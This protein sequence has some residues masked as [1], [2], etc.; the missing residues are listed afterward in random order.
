M[1]AMLVRGRLFFLRMRR[2]GWT[3]VGANSIAVI[4]NPWSV[5][6]QEHDPKHV[7]GRQKRSEQPDDP[8]QGMAAREGLVK[9]LVLAEKSREAGHYCDRQR[10]DDEGPVCQPKIVLQTAWS[11]GVLFAGERVDA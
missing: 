10:A 4:L 5:E 9:D 3:K 7:D 6:R 2:H 1:C 11:A 8:Q